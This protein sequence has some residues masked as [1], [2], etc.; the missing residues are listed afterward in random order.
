VEKVEFIRRM[1]ERKLDKMASA[2]R[3]LHSQA[4]A[5]EEGGKSLLTEQFIRV[6]R[7]SPGLVKFLQGWRDSCGSLYIPRT[8]ARKCPEEEGLIKGSQ[9]E[10]K[11][12]AFPM[13]AQ[14]RVRVCMRRDG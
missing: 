3:T 13:N 10:Y 1:L 14:R 6:S 8:G 12:R 2:T 9:T 11:I 7:L 5:P 4:K